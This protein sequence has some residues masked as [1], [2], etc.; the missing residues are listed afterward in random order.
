MFIDREA[1]ITNIKVGICCFV[2]Y[3]ERLNN[4]LVNIY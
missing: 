1:E 2:V 4:C 3:Y